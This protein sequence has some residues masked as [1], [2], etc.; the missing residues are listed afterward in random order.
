V[1]FGA[2][3]NEGKRKGG[4]EN[5]KCETLQSKR[6]DGDQSHV[7]NW[8]PGSNFWHITSSKNPLL[9]K[10]EE[11]DRTIEDFSEQKKASFL[12]KK[13]YMR[14]GEK[15]IREN[16]QITHERNNPSGRILRPKKCL[17]KFFSR[18]GRLLA[19]TRV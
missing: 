7:L 3:L 18:G 9:K 12:K 1:D 13:K 2:L 10:L 15:A 8:S 5:R 11:I 14:W 19:H 4:K 17:Y 6:W 16:K